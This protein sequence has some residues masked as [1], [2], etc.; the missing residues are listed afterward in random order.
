MQSCYGT[1]PKCW[2][3]KNVLAAGTADDLPPPYPSNR[4]IRGSGRVSGNGRA[5]VPA[6]S[7]TRAHTD[8]ATQIHHL[9]QEAYCSVL[10]AFKAQS[11]AITWVVNH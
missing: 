3:F 9:E 5:I 7:Y 4:G 11:D 1:F 10:R 6:G 8:M 2:V